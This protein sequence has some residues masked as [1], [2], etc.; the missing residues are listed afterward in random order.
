MMLNNISFTLG[1][2]MGDGSFQI[3]H[4]KRKYLQYRIII[5]LKNTPANL[6]MLQDQR[7]FYKFGTIIARKEFVIWAIN[8][9]KQVKQF[10]GLI[11]E[12]PILSHKYLAKLKIL[13]MLY[14]INNN[15]SYSE[16]SFLEGSE[17]WSWPFDKPPFPINPIVDFNENY[18]WWLSG[19]VEAEGYFCIRKN[20]NQSFS[21]SQKNGDLLLNSIKVFLKLPNKVFQKKCGTSVLETY[22]SRCCFRVIEFFEDYPLKG[23]KYISFTRFKNYLQSKP[24]K[25]NKVGSGKGNN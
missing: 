20:G 5:K 8:D 2:L 25:T 1:L 24:A 22:N 13:K 9:K 4:W 19:F 7:S 14:G 21:V 17:C 3:N 6:K 23:E 15:I 16:Y 18:K 10:L 12:N 11:V